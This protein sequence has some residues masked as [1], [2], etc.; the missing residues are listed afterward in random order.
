MDYL[1]NKLNI[2]VPRVLGYC[3]RASETELGAEYIIMEKA[4]GVELAQVWGKIKSR[5][6]VTLV[7]QLADI[8]AKL[9]GAQFPYYGSLYYRKDISE[10][11]GKTIDN[12]FT[13]GPTTARAWFDDRRDEVN[14]H[15]GPWES[16]SEVIN[17]LARRE[18]ACINTFATSS[19]DCQQGIFNG[20][21]GY[22]PTNQSKL[23]VLNDFEKIFR[24]ILPMRDSLKTG[25]IWHND[26]H[27]DNIFV[28]TTDSNQITSII[29]WQAT[30]IY[31]MFL[32]THHPSL[33]E[34]EGPKLEGYTQ[35]VLPPNIKEMSPRTKQAAKDLFL[36]Q[37]LWL[38]YETQIQKQSPD[39]LH[40]FRY[41]NTHQCQLLQ[42]IGTIFDDGEPYIQ[43]LIADIT[44]TEVW[45]KIVGTSVS[46]T[47]HIPCPIHYSEDELRAQRDQFAVWEKDVDR[48]QQVITEIGAYTGWNGAVSPDEFDEM[49]RRLDAAKKR[50]LDREARTAEERVAWES[51]WPFQDHT[52]V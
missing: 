45:E 43:S 27:A 33:V 7:K 14:I 20:P 8:T 31:P 29:D 36:S 44:S 18:A 19:R 3:S 52:D 16:A 10:T 11:E 25:I 34:F 26:L 22:S 51:V 17:A 46:G 41:A 40:A 35:P 5:D 9:S 1:K 28:D 2:P 23:A 37:S 13:I 21:G 30:P 42:A 50:F 12:T 49:S 32:S 15:R 38:L 4:P 39:L 47:P 6:K 48:R 24:H